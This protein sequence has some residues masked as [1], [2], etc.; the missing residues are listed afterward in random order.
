MEARTCYA[1]VVLIAEASRGI[2][3]AT[4]KLLGQHGA[5]GVNTNTMA[6]KLRLRK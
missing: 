6:V 4:A 3:A 1:N 2:G 5:V